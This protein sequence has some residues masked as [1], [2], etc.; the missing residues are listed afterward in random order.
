MDLITEPF[1]HTS[2][3]RFKR[4]ARRSA[5]R[6]HL[7]HKMAEDGPPATINTR[8]ELDTAADRFQHTVNAILE[9]HV[10]RARPSPYARKWWTEK[11]TTLR[12]SLSAVRNQL[13]V[14]R[15]RGD[16]VEDAAAK[17][18]L[19]RRLY[20]DEI[21]R[22]KRQHWSEFLDDRHNVWK[23][24][25]YAKASKGRRSIPS[26]KVEGDEVSDDA[27]K[28]TAFLRSFFPIPP[29]PQSE[30][31][32]VLKSLIAKKRSSRIYEQAGKK[33]PAR[34][35]CSK[36]TTEEVKAAIMQAKPDKAPGRDEITFRVWQELWS[37]VKNE[38][39]RLYRASLEL[40]YVPETWRTAKIVVLR[41]PNKP[42]YS[43][44]KAYRPISLL[45]TLSKG[46]ETIVARRLSYLAETY[47]LLPENHF[48]GRPRRSGEQALNVLIEK[49]YEAW[50][51]Q[52]VL[53]LVSFDVQ[54]AFNGVHT[55]VLCQRL[56]E[57]RIPEDLVLWI[58]SFCSN[59]KASV[60]V[61]DFESPVQDIAHAGIPQGSPLSTLLYVFYNAN[62]VQGRFEKSGGSIG[63]I[64]DYSA[65]VTGPSA[66]ANRQVLQTQLIPKV[67]GWARQSGAV[68]EA[69]KTSFIHF[70]RRRQAEGAMEGMLTF[71]GQDVKPSSTVKVLGVTLNSRL[72][73]DE[74]IAQTASRAM[75]KCMALRMIRG[76][77]P[78]QMR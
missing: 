67:E 66:E 56:R 31:V 75:G 43:K 59:R 9:R 58:Q 72:T 16:A 6:R 44:A 23:A 77:R 13:T 14:T 78:L 37:V 41:K 57:R 24:Y 11:L 1:G 61:G 36:L 69:E 22:R 20:M 35:K 3:F 30:E 50:R 70:T 19:A 51:G 32:G 60:V 25:A 71:G 74:H 73:M 34:I 15:R 63:F 55:T 38:V 42:D 76:A 48:G 29:P 4:G 8:D 47:R 46:L 45:E 7:E 64:D 49:I 33:A 52:R 12:D 39:M 62:L 17:V 5:I 26:L 54:G 2:T 53:S 40:R 18:R 10:G 27:G 21:D 28:A 68:F 65:W